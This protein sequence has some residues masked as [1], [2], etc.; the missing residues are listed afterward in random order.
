MV[1]KIGILTSGGDAPG[2]NSAIRAVTRVAL[3]QGIQVVG[4]Y[5]GYKGL[6]EGKMKEFTK[7][8][9]SDIANR[10]GTILGSARLPE[11]KEEEV[12]LKA[13]AMLKEKG[14]DALVVIGGDG[15]YRGALSLTKHGINCVG[16]PGTID[17][18]IPGTDFT[19]G[20]DTALNT[21][22][23]C[24]DKLRDTSSSHHRC[25]IVELMGNRCG[26]LSIFSGLSCG[27]E[28][29]IT[30]ETGYD[31]E[32]I[33]EKLNYLD[34]IGK[35]HALVIVSEKITD[36]N[37]LAKKVS[38]N[39]GFSG[40]ATILGHIQRGGAPTAS[41]RILAAR[42]GE[43]AVDLLVDGIGGVC[44]GIIDN[45]I[46]YLPIEEAL[47]TRKVQDKA[48]YRLFDRLI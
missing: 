40:R 25:S 3:S 18:D 23:E 33:F 29:V 45:K 39:T 47:T 22:V 14:I 12:Q 34:N 36:V 27:A 17:N 7:S 37:A 28:V 32:E 11:F 10:G 35:N 19:I 43:E 41:D 4:I 8:D 38:E 2:M 30:K 44:C 21:A 26:D 48:L 24:I 15:S 46:T 13:V 9:V 16:L 6:I 1:N 42:L 31:E 20:Y 5:D